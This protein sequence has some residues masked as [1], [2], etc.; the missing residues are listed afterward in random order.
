[1]DGKDGNR[2]A[3]PVKGERKRDSQGRRFE[4]E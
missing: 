1:M 4:S 2:R 3:R